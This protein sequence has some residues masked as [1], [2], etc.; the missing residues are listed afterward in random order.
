MNG[1]PLLV[2]RVKQHVYY[3]G[4][5]VGT[6]WHLTGSCSRTVKTAPNM[7]VPIFRIMDQLPYQA[8]RVLLYQIWCGSNRFLRSQCES[9][10]FVLGLLIANLMW[11]LETCRFYIQDNISARRILLRWSMCYNWL[12][13]WQKIKVHFSLVSIYL[14]FTTVCRRSYPGVLEYNIFKHTHQSN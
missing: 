1:T 9:V 2:Q 14:P 7:A 3:I 5:I 13:E 6:G 11:S 12:E 4:R 8:C 10:L